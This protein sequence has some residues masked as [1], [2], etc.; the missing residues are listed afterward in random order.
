MIFWGYNKYSIISI[1]TKINGYQGKMTEVHGHIF[2]VMILVHYSIS[3]TWI[4]ALWG[5]F[6]H[7]SSEG[8]QT[9]PFDSPSYVAL[10]ACSLETNGYAHNHETLWTMNH[11]SIKTYVIWSM[12]IQLPENLWA[13]TKRKRLMRFYDLHGSTMIQTC[14]SHA[15]RQFN[16][17]NIWINGNNI[18]IHGYYIYIR[19]YIYI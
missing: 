12:D 17:Y 2:D 3:L 18:Y 15:D 7:D 16:G 5:R 6:P 9:G 1:I 10:W 14:G 13:I 19:T 8:E 4:E 11:V